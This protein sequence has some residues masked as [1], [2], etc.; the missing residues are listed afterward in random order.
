MSGGA[1]R[2][3]TSA[4]TDREGGRWWRPPG[5]ADAGQLPMAGH[6]PLRGVPPPTGWWEGRLAVAGAS[7]W[8]PKAQGCGGPRMGAAPGARS[9]A[10]MGVGR[11]PPGGLQA[12]IPP[13][14]RR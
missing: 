3:P 11:T 8:P 14:M 12:A 9:P 13:D 6:A 5:G 7:C 1:R 2:R 10:E 4:Q